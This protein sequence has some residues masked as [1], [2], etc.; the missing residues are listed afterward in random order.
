MSNSYEIGYGKPPKHTRFKKGQSGNPK[1]RPAGTRNLK[2]DLQEELS[3]RIQIREGK[4]QLTVS[5]QRAMVKNLLHK[6]VKGDARATNLVVNMMLRLLDVGDASGN[7]A[8][9]SAE[10]QEVLAALERRLL[11]R[12]NRYERNTAHEEGTS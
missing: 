10:E 2:T 8:P 1:G 5:K 12:A 7:E 4:R 6:A 11:E 3:E 9:I